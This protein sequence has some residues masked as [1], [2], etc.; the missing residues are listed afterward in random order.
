MDDVNDTCH[1]GDYQFRPCVDH[2]PSWYPAKIL[3]PVPEDNAIKIYL[4]PRRNTRHRLRQP[5]T[6]V[7]MNMLLP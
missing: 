2:R 7:L 4:F 6:L 5:K 3:S 1:N